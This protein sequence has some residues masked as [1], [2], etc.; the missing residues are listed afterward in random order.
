MTNESLSGSPTHGLSVQHADALW[1]A[2]AIP[3][4]R[5]PTFMEQHERVCRT[6]AEI[7][8]EVAPVSPAGPAPATD[9]DDAIASCPGY[10]TSPNPCRCPCYGCKHHCSAHTPEDVPE[11]DD[12]D[13][14]EADIDRMTAAGTPV[15]IVTEPPAT[16]SAAVLPAPAQQTAEPLAVDP[17]LLLRVA[18]HLTRSADQLWP[19]GGSVMH[20]DATLLRRLA[21]EAQQDEE[22]EAA[23]DLRGGPAI[24]PLCPYP[25][26]LHTPSGAR[27]HFTAVHPEQRLTGRG[28]GPWPLLMPTTAAQQDEHACSNCDGV[29]P[30]T[31]FMNPNRPPEQCPRSEADGYG[32]QC[33]KPA[34]HN[35]CTFEEQPAADGRQ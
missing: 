22:R 27:A 33:Q 26:T 9:R 24:C 15:Q 21:G 18:D 20:A 25:L 3:G 29:D 28:P 34:G 12:T 8:S 1:D 11:P 14:T 23:L 17:A 5:T 6:V 13:L 2:V 16:Y 35:L 31:C 19:D 30:D 4:P 10:E 32:L 7:I